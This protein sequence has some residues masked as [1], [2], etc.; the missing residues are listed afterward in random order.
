MQEPP[1]NSPEWLWLPHLYHR[2]GLPCPPLTP[3]TRLA[4]EVRVDRRAPL[5]VQTLSPQVGGVP[6]L[7]TLQ[8]GHSN[9]PLRLSKLSPGVQH[10]PLCLAWTF[11]WSL[12]GSLLTD[13]LKVSPL[14]R[15]CCCSSCLGDWHREPWL[16][17][18]AL[19]HPNCRSKFGPTGV[20]ITANPDVV[21][22]SSGRHRKLL[23]PQLM[24]L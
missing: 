24:Q 13:T 4:H 7:R 22:S 10:G 19:S 11:V 18:P 15:R 16:P 20:M 8:V 1:R 23:T 9:F 2:W 6:G 12:R 3:G 21:L 14:T 17:R 5:S